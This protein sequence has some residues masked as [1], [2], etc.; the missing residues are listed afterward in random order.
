MSYRAQ[1]KLAESV[2]AEKLGDG[3]ELKLKEMSREEKKRLALELMDRGVRNVFALVK[4]LRISSQTLRRLLEGRRGAVE[5]GA[6]GADEKEAIRLRKARADEA[7]PILAKEIED[8]AWFHNLLHDVGKYVFHGLVKHV[9]WT[10]EHVRDEEKAFEAIAKFFDSLVEA[11]V[12]KAK[13]LEELKVENMALDAYLTFS[14]DLLEK[15]RDRLLEYTRFADLAA[16][17]VCP[18][19]RLKLMAQLIAAQAAG[20][21]KQAR[22]LQV[23]KRDVSRSEGA[24]L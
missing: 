11:G 8:A 16:R 23:T 21:T 22:T 15:A 20:G 10:E 18:S 24:S 6:G 3:W 4:A 13:A 5:G 9:D 7:R 12:E 17:T 19:C 14:I 1:L 2:L